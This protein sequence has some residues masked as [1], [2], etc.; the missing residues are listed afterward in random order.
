ATAGDS[1]SGVSASQVAGTTR[2]ILNA[3]SFPRFVTELING[4]FKAILDSSIQQM[5]SFVDL[6]NNVSAST[7]GF[8]DAHMGPDRARAW[9]VERYPGSFELEDGGED[10]EPGARL[11]L[12]DGAPLPSAAALKADLGLADTETI[13][14]GDPERTLLPLARNRLAKMQQ[15][16]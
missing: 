6:L 13:P 7:E 16:K 11:R 12:R 10:N 15:E 3:V 8:A 14:T 2:A 9:L 1:F 5:H 4:V